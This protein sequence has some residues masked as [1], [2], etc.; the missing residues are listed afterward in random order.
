MIYKEMKPFLP[1]ITQDNL[2]KKT[3]RARKLLLLFGKDGVGIDKIKQVTYSANEISKLT[4]VQIQNIINQ[5]TLKT[6]PSGNDQTNMTLAMPAPL[7]KSDV[8]VSVSVKPQINISMSSKSQASDS[9]GSITKINLPPISQP[10]KITPHSAR[11]SYI[12][13]ILKDHSYLSLRHSNPRSDSYA[14]DSL[15]AC[16][17]C[18][19]EHNKG[20][21]IGIYINDSYNIKCRSCSPDSF[22]GCDF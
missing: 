11:A 20:F 15:G 14:F 7:K 18:K 6:V 21:I 3:L 1:N 19:Q 12:N 22:V 5:V 13:T 8:K 9:S 17:K 16:P 10:R 2:R 4:N